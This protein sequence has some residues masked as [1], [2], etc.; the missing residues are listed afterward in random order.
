MT[1]EWCAG[2]T[3]HLRQQLPLKLRYTITI[4][5][6][7]RQ[8]NDETVINL[9]KQEMAPGCTFVA[10]LRVRSLE[11][12]VLEPMTFQRLA[13]ISNNRHFQA[14]FSKESHLQ[15]LAAQT[16]QCFDPTSMDCTSSVRTAS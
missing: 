1:F 5:K 4:H 11:D 6:S 12:C 8:T 3:K 7:Q 10:T 15:Q 14:R 9:G 13:S 16:K 2:I